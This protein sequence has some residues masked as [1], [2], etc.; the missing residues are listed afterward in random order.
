MNVDVPFVIDAIDRGVSP[1]ETIADSYYGSSYSY[2]SSAAKKTGFLL[3]AY[4]VGMIFG[5]LI[6]GYL[7]K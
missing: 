2:F 3:A 7:G 1:E 6:I 4:A 5:S